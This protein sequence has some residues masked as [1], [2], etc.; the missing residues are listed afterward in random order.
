MTDEPARGL[1]RI[2]FKLRHEGPAW[3]GRR[4]S[5]ETDNPSTRPGRLIHAAFRRGLIV[6]RALP[7]LLHGRGSAQFAEANTVLYA[8]YDLQVAPITFDFLWFLTAAD[9][10]RRRQGLEKIH[11]VIVPARH[12]RVRRERSD[13]EAVVSPLAREERIQTILFEACQLLPSCAGVTE[14]S[15]RAEADF[16]RSSARHIFPVDYDTMLPTLPTSRVCLDAARRGDHPIAVLR[17][18][19]ERKANIEHWLTARGVGPRRLVTITLRDYA[20]MPQRNSNLQAWSDFARGLD[21]KLFYPVVIPDTD[22]TLRGLPS[23]IDGLTVFVEAAWN[24]GLRMALYERADLNMGVNTGPMGLCWLNDT[25]RYAT[26]KMA[27]AG[28]PQTTVENFRSL[29]FDPDHSLP[30]ANVGQ[31]LVWQDDT[32]EAIQDTFARLTRLAKSAAGG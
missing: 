24:V 12:G 5:A 25:T 18:R 4:I 26:L 16:F 2:I 30:F 13:Y 29:G 8:F 21:S 22:Q 32:L 7:R 9:L 14:A 27:P 20:Y 23:A 31:E 15:S 17:A 1:P 28:V 10:H 6:A 3:I 11:V 19:P